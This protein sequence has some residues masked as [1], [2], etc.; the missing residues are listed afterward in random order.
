LIFKA[1]PLVLRLLYLIFI[2]LQKVASLSYGQETAP[3]DPTTQVY[4]Q[5][6]IFTH[7]STPHLFV[8]VPSQAVHHLQALF[9]AQSPEVEQTEHSEE[10]DSQL[11]VCVTPVSTQKPPTHLYPIARLQSR[12]SVHTCFSAIPKITNSG[13]IVFKINQALN[14]IIK[15]NKAEKICSFASDIA[16]GEPAEI[17]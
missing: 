10:Q 17:K 9:V 11:L 7:L 6:S 8:E 12:S 15:P 5:S 1:H 3:H 16:T 13:L 14:K 2:Y 4:M